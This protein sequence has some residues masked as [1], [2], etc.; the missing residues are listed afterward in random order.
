MYALMS[1]GVGISPDAI[2]YLN[3]AR[4]VLAGQGLV[5]AGLPM[6]HFPPVYPLLLAAIGLVDPACCTRPGC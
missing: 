2:D 4:S 5:I 3:T 1:H 6:T